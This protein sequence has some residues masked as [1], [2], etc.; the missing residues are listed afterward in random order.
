MKITNA[1][2]IKTIA[3]V[4]LGTATACQSTTAVNKADVNPPAETKQANAAKPDINVAN[5]AATPEITT[6]QADEPAAGALETPH[7]A[8]KFA[9]AARQ[10]K[11]VAALKRV[12]SKDALEFLEMMTE[13]GKTID[14]TLLKMTET[15][16][17]DTDV[18]R[19]EKTTGDR[20]TLEYPD[21]QG[22][23]KTMDLVREDGEWK[24]T[25]P[26]ADAP[27]GKK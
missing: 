11:D 18:W 8:Y 10:K 24:I 5:K 14:D 15:P 27:A 7:D 16:Q 13:D 26:K 1:L 6:K 22:K 23:W 19:S 2:I 12:M 9:Y 17:A 3:L 21:A 20:A 25:F 4:A